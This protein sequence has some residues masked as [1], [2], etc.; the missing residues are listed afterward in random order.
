MSIASNPEDSVVGV[1]VDGVDGVDGVRHPEFYYVY[2]CQSP[3]LNSATLLL[4]SHHCV[5]V[6]TLSLLAPDLV[7]HKNKYLSDF[8]NSGLSMSPQDPP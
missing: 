6:L 4:S 5:I 2:S 1:G 8:V 3:E 7:P